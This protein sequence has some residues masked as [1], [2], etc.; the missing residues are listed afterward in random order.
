MWNV[1]A[2]HSE[3]DSVNGGLFHCGCAFLHLPGLVWMGPGF[4]FAGLQRLWNICQILQKNANFS[5]DCSALAISAAS[6]NRFG[7]CVCVCVARV[8]WLICVKS[9][10]NGSD[11]LR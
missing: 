7:V 4:K 8:S 2:K 10:N 3:N 6:S 1:D 9:L 11:W 5:S